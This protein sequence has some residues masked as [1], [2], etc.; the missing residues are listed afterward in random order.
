MSIHAIEK[1]TPF[2]N[3]LSDKQLVALSKAGSDYAT[4]CLIRR[5]KGF[6]RLKA[7]S[8][9]LIGADREDLVQEGMIGLYKAI[10]DFRSDKGTSFQTFAELCVTR[11]MITAIKT[12]TRLKHAPLNCYISLNKSQ[13]FKEQEKRTLMDKLSSSK[14]SDPIEL[15]INYEEAG[16]IRSC[17]GMM[18][19]GLEAGVLEL[20]L[21]G[22]S[23]EEIAQGLNKHTKSVDNA[24]QRVKK[25]IQLHLK[26]QSQE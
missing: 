3:N 8:Y 15:I 18:L 5:Y 16:K 21:D 14:L 19:S 20:Y 26:H 1:V 25:K 7:R 13:S 11:Q 10:K 4:Y 24:L 9:F 6:V 22:K 2:Y 17:L 12:A 23:Y